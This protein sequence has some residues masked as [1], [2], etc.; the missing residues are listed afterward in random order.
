MFAHTTDTVCWAA[1]WLTWLKPALPQHMPLLNC[2][3]RTFHDELEY[4]VHRTQ[5]SGEGA[6]TCHGPN[7]RHRRRAQS[8]RGG[9]AGWVRAA[10]WGRLPGAQ[11]LQSAFFLAQQLRS[12]WFCLSNMVFP[13]TEGLDNGP[14]SQVSI[15]PHR[16][17][18]WTSGAITPRTP[19]TSC[20][21]PTHS[22][23]AT[24]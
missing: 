2:Q 7:V 18:M 21:K 8:K 9:L 4:V 6:E 24:A 14:L 22:W 11:S 16:W 12:L 19:S 23:C 3:T 5:S 15:M 17:T 10:L 13:S 20:Q 1:G